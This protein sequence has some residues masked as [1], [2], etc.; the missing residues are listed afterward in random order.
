MKWIGFLTDAAVAGF[1]LLGIISIIGSNSHRKNGIIKAVTVML[2]IFYLTFIPGI[3][4]YPR[5]KIPVIPYISIFAALGLGS[6]RQYTW[7]KGL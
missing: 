5:F 7:K 6:T 1:S 3:L 2:L 4:G